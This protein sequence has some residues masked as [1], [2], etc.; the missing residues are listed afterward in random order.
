MHVKDVA[1]GSNALSM[2]HAE[3]V[4]LDGVA[5]YQSTVAIVGF[6]V[7]LENGRFEARITTENLFIAL[8]AWVNRHH[9]GANVFGPRPITL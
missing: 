3:I 7:I 5:K 8:L 6:R 4:F 2:K 1:S 9:L